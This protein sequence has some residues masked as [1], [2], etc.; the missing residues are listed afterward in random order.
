M[1]LGTRT[2]ADDLIA[3]EGPARLRWDGEESDGRIERFWRRNELT[4]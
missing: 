3:V 1:T 2:G 4:G